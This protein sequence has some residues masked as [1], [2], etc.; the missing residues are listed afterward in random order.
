MR[1]CPFCIRTPTSHEIHCVHNK[2][3]HSEERQTWKEWYDIGIADTNGRHGPLQNDPVAKLGY[4]KGQRDL[5]IKQRIQRGTHE[6]EPLPL[7]I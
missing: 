3:P 6:S 4:Y 5:R 1:D 7:P 2:H